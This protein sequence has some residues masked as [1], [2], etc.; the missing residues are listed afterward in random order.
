M[1]VV[2]SYP[3]NLREAEGA[4]RALK[5]QVGPLQAGAAFGN[6]QLE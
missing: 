4:F 1:G 2:G 5:W 6:P 3:G